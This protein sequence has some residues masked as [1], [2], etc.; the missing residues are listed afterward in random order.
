[1]VANAVSVEG[2]AR[3]AEL[4]ARLGGELVRLAVSRVEPIGQMRGWRSAMAVTQ[5]RAIKP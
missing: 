5:W 2:E 3:L 4:H 1:M